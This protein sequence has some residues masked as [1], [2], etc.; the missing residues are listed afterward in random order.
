MF[1]AFPSH[2]FCRSRYGITKQSRPLQSLCLSHS[3][4]LLKP[5]L[6]LAVDISAA[7]LFVFL[8]YELLYWFVLA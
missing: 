7:N 8:V 5:N 2:L 4:G 6:I 3:T 1:F